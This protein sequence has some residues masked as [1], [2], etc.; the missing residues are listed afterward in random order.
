MWHTFAL[1]VT[2]Q[3]QA[4]SQRRKVFQKKKKRHKKRTSGVLLSLTHTHPSAEGR[5]KIWRGDVQYF[6]HPALIHRYLFFSGL[7]FNLH[8]CES[9]RRFRGHIC[10]VQCVYYSSFYFL[11]PSQSC[12]ALFPLSV[13]VACRISLCL[14]LHADLFFSPLYLILL[15]PQTSFITKHIMPLS[16]FLFSLSSEH[17]LLPPCGHVG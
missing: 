8:I 12:W 10:L 11:L 9:T 3:Q 17:P 4:R 6:S 14:S 2:T 13:S 7:Y 1:Q 5:R 15:C 16:F